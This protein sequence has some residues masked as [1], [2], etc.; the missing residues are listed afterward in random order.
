MLS[1]LKKKIDANPN[2]IREKPPKYTIWEEG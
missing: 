2:A 1:V